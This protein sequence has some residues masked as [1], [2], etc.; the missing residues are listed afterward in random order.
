MHRREVIVQGK[1]TNEGIMIYILAVYSV[2]EFLQYLLA[3]LTTRYAPVARKTDGHS[4]R[5]C[6]AD[7]PDNDRHRHL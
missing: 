6:E 3:F 1:R 7:P 4:R 5:D 2:T